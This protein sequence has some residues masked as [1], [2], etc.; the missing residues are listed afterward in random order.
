MKI[1]VV[2]KLTKVYIEIDLVVLV[3]FK[4]IRRY[5]EILQVLKVL[6]TKCSRSFFS[7]LE[8]LIRTMEIVDRQTDTLERL[9][10]LSVYYF[11]LS[12]INLFTNN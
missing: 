10:L 7:Y 9:L 5:R 3:V 12:I 8:C 6:I 11:I 2:L 1:L 4:E